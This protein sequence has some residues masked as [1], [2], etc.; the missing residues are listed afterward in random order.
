MIVVLLIVS[1][2]AGTIPFGLIIA[3]SR[4]IDLR[5]VG[6]GNIGATNV[7]R[8]VGK[9]EALFTLTGDLMKGAFAVALMKVS[10]YGDPYTALAGL[11]A[12]TGH[13]YPVF[14]RF[15]GGKGVATSIGALLV[16]APYVGLLTVLIW[17]AVIFIFRYSSLGALTAFTLLP[18]NMIIFKKGLTGL[19]LS[20]LF[21][22][23]I[24]IKHRENIRRL[25]QGKEPGVGQKKNN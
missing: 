23:L 24:Y 25:L 6:S 2:I 11:V 22:I 3:K 19:S 17:L 1:Y 20:L 13:D 18:L 16:Y 15:R 21:A 14:F 10:G 4:G 12:V 9:K 7:L 8:T 5:R